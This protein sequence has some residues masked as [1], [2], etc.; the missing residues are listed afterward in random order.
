MVGIYEGVCL[1]SE[2]NY[3]ITTLKEI[4][5]ANENRDKTVMSLMISNESIM[6]AL[7]ILHERIK[8]LEN[9]K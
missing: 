7:T 4:L 1:M 6:K 5:K 9:N 2:M 3:V 8:K